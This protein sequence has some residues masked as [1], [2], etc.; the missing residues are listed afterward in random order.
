MNQDKFTKFTQIL[1]V[2]LVLVII[3]LLVGGYGGRTDTGTSLLPPFLDLGLP[4]VPAEQQIAQVSQITVLAPAVFH[5]VARQFGTTYFYSPVL[6]YGP[7]PIVSAELKVNNAS[8][9]NVNLQLFPYPVAITGYPNLAVGIFTARANI[10][11]AGD[12]ITVTVTD[13]NGDPASKTVP[14]RRF[15]SGAYCF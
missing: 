14:C 4:N 6:A 9:S 7:A 12:Q 10:V 8:V 3:V 13:A 1:L 2:I 15:S 11:K 5:F